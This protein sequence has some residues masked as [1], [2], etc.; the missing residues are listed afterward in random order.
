ME[1]RGREKSGKGSRENKTCKSKNMTGAAR[2]CDCEGHSRSTIPEAPQSG[3]CADTVGLHPPC[4]IHAHTQP[5]AMELGSSPAPGASSLGHAA[6]QSTASPAQGQRL[7]FRVCWAAVPLTAWG[8]A[9]RLRRRHWPLSC[10]RNVPRPMRKRAVLL[11]EGTGLLSCPTAG[12][13]PAAKPL[14]L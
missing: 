6:L 8:D 13:H 9:P 11:L 10:E 7:R 12:Q 14:P 4:H 5:P 3:P 2:V 1:G